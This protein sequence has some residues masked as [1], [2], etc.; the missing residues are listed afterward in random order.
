M[1]SPKATASSQK[2]VWRIATSGRTERSISRSDER[3]AR[4]RPVAARGRLAVGQQPEVGGIAP[5]EREHR[6]QHQDEDATPQDVVGTRA[7]RGARSDTAPAGAKTMPPAEMP[8]V[9]MP[10]ARPRRT[11]NQRATAALLGSAPMQVEP[12]ATGPARQR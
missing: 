3:E 8:A 10:S 2:L 11:T 7:S 5:H 1:V 4:L 9:A 12:S 6:R